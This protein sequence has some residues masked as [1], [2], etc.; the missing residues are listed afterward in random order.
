MNY[1]EL[2]KKIKPELEKV[3]SFYERELQKLR[4]GRPSLSLIEEIPV[5]CFGKKVPLKSLGAISSSGPREF[6]IQP[7]DRIYLEAI[8]KAIYESPLG[9]TPVV[10]KETVRISFPPLTEE[11]RKDLISLL[12]KKTDEAKRAIRRWRDK[13]SKEIQNRFLAG[14]LSEDDKYRAKDKL[15]DLIEEYND[16]IDELR[17]KK[18]EE[19]FAE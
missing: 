18:E 19:I 12:G 10:E 2:I 3:V 14:E 5:D 8:E 7:W 16:K 13:V 1:E 17:E 9:L 4:S 15:Q 6:R 11:F